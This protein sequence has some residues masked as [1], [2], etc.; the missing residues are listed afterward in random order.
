MTISDISGYCA[1]T[2]ELAGFCNDLAGGLIGLDS[3]LQ[4]ILDNVFLFGFLGIGIVLVGFLMM[5]LMKTPSRS[6][7]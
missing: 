3:V 5:G 2:Q 6:R 4:A 1:A 7:F